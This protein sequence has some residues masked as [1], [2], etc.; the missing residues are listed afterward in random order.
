[1]ILLGY[2]V[3]FAYIFALIFLLGPVINKF[4]GT[5]FSRKIVHVML[6]LVWTFIDIFFRHTLHQIIIP[7][8]FLILNSL[9]YKF[10]FY[11][12]VERENENHLG[13]VYFAA[14][15]TV[16]LTV[17]YFWRDFYYPSGISVFCLTFGDGFAALIGYHIKTRK[18]RNHKS[19]GGTLACFLATAL[20]I[21]VFNRCYSLNV[22]VWG[23]IAIALLTAILEMAENGLDNFTIVAGTFLLSYGLIRGSAAGLTASVF[24]A[25]AV[26]LV[27]FLSGAISYAGTVLAMVLVFSFSF[28]GGLFVLLYLLGLYFSIFAISL[29]K[30]KL[31]HMPKKEKSRNFIQ[32][33]INGG[34]SLLFML[35]YGIQKDERFLQISLIAVGGCFIDSLSSDVGVLSTKEPYDPIKA[36]TVTRGMSGG[37]SALGTGAALLGSVAIAMAVGIGMNLGVGQAVFVGAMVFAQTVV[38]T[39]LGSL[40]QAKYLCEHCGAPTEKKEHCGAPARLTGGIPWINNNMVNV[41]SSVIITAAAAAICLR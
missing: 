33:L 39:V 15:I 20:A 36:K 10:K 31:L 1:M 41:I 40:L 9:S 32:I 38:D 24:A 19:L 7:V 17:A 37:V 13:T 28:Y 2:I 4:L 22:S 6:F 25:M 8:V 5:E 3:I 16:I 11:K 26:F 34:M 23:V 21:F 35:A 18:L 12:S 29:A 30:R 27:V 14:A